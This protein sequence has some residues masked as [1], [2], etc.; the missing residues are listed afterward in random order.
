MIRKAYT[1]LS[2]RK[3]E[4]VGRILS[5]EDVRE[6]LAEGDIDSPAELAPKVLKTAPGLL[7]LAPSF[8]RALFSRSPPGNQI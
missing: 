1:K 7:R 4:E 6:V 3:L 8:L 5:R 2:D